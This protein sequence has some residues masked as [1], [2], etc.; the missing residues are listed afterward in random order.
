MQGDSRLQHLTVTSLVRTAKGVILL[1][2]GKGKE[3]L[4]LNGRWPEVEREL[5]EFS[6]AMGMGTEKEKGLNER[7]RKLPLQF[8]R[9]SAS[10]N[11]VTDCPSPIPA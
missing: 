3:K 1:G 10:L 11:D 2:Q 5:D 8:R 4:D 7:C 9:I 6:E